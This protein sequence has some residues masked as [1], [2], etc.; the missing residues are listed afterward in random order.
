MIPARLA[1]TAFA[2]A[3]GFPGGVRV[4]RVG[5]DHRWFAGGA[6]VLPYRGR[7]PA[8]CTVHLVAATEAAVA[9]ALALTG[10]LAAPLVLV[11][12]APPPPTWSARRV[13]AAA[14]GGHVAVAATPAAAAAYGVPHLPALSAEAALALA[15]T[16]PYFPLRA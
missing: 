7:V 3:A 14:R 5:P 1:R 15:R 9:E 12:T 16:T 4:L 8:G 10:G 13:G 11:L 6:D 2:A